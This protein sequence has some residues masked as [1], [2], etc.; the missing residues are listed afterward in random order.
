MLRPGRLDRLLYVGVAED[1]ESKHNVLCA[2]TRSFKLAADVDLEAVAQVSYKSAGA[3]HLLMTSAISG[4]A[5]AKHAATA[6]A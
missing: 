4:Q 1:I 3:D 5:S 2:L 6:L